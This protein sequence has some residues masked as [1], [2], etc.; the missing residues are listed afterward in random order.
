[1]NSKNKKDIT[2]KYFAKFLSAK[3]DKKMGMEEIISM[4]SQM[5]IDKDGIISVNDLETFLQRINFNEFFT[6]SIKNGT[7]QSKTQSNSLKRTTV[8]NFY[9]IEQKLYPNEA[10]QKDKLREVIKQLK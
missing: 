9:H 1:M 3:I 7:Q 6:K 8:Q 2:V 4:T 5:D 10:P